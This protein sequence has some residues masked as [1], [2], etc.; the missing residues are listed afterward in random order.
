MKLN[1]FHQDYYPPQSSCCINICPPFIY[2]GLFVCLGGHGFDAQGLLL[3]V[4]R[5]LS[6]TTLRI[7]LGI[8][9]RSVIYKA[10]PSLLYYHSGPN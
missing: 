3:S 10:S 1:I 2:W 8:E 7:N 5:N 4:H 9:P 6:R